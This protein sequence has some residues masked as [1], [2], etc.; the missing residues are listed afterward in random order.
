MVIAEKKKAREQGRRYAAEFIENE[1][2]EGSD[3]E[4]HDDLIKKIDYDAEEREYEG[5]DLDAD[6][7]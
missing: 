5:V 7:V 3:N 2:E 1:A 6:L 4:E